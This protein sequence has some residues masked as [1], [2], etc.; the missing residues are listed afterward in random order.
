VPS[1][2]TVPS[3]AT[4]VDA[5][6]A[7]TRCIDGNEAVA[8]AAYALSETV[9][10]Y[11]ITPASPMGEFADEWAAKGRPNAWGVVPSV[12]QLQSEAGAAGAL[13][14]A[15]QAGSLGVTFTASQGLL[16]MIPEMFRIAGELTPTVIHVAA[17]TVATHA[18]SIFGDHSDVMAVR[19]TG[20]VMLSS[21]TPQEAH[22]LAAVSHAATLE[23]RLPFLHFMDGFRTSHELNVVRPIPEADLRR[24]IDEEALL[25][26]RGRGLDPDHPVLRGSA[27]NP[28]VFFQAR[29]AANTYVS[30]VPGIVQDVMDR[31]AAV[32]GRHY[33]LVEYHGAPDAEHVVV[34]MG[35]AVGPVR[36]VVDHLIS[37]AGTADGADGGAR[38]KVGLLY[39]RLFRPFPVEAFLAA[40]PTTVRRIAVL[41]RTK[42][43]GA[44]GEPLLEEVTTALAEAVMH[45][46]RDRLPLVVGARYGLASKEFTPAMVAGLF[47][48]L[49]SAA[50]KRRMTIGIID[51]VTGLSIPP[52]AGFALP[53]GPRDRSAVFFGL[54]ADGTVGANKN[55]TKIVGDLTDLHTQGYFVYDSK[56]S[57]ATT[58]SHL[59][60]SPDPIHS[61]YLIE[62]ADL[63]ACHQFGLLEKLDVT[64]SLKDGGILLLNAPFEADALFA[65]LPGA[66]RADIVA[67]GLEVH[68]IDAYRIAREVGLGGRINTVMQ[69]AYFALADLVDP[70]LAIGAIERAIRTSYGNRGE[71]VV[72]RNLAAVAQ[73]RS[74]L[75][76]IPV[77]TDAGAVEGRIDP[78]ERA[79]A[80]MPAG[81]EASDFVRR[82]TARMLEGEGELL[83]VS[84]LPVDGTFPTA[85]SRFEKRSLATELPIWDPDLCIDCGKCAIV[86]P[87]TAIQMK[88][89]EPD[90]LD[91]APDVFL[92]KEFKDRSLTGHLLTVQVAPDDCTGCGVCVETCPAVSRSDA[93]RK[94][95]RME[96][97]FE[98]R[99]V[100]RERYRFFDDIPYVDRSTVRTDTVKH[101]QLLQPLFE[102]SGAC[103]GCG[104][105]PYLKLLSQLYG[106]RSVVANATGCS[107]IYGGNLPTTPWSVDAAGR[108]PAWA[109]S[110]FEDNAEFGLGIRLGLDQQR[111]VAVHLLTTLGGEIGDE[112]VGSLLEADQDDEAEIAAQRERVVELRRRLAGIGGTHA[113]DARRLDQLA[114]ALVKRAV[115]IVG[116]DGW[117]YDIGYGGLD[118]V[119]ASGADVNVLVLDTE[120]Y[121]NTGGQ[122]SKSTNRAAVAKY[123]TSGKSSAKK[124]L[125]LIAMQYGTVYVAQIA[126]GANEMQTVKAFH[127]A[128][129]W[130]GPSLLL[131]Y[132]TCIA[133]GVDMRDS[134]KRQDLAVRTGYWPLFRYHP[135]E[136]A[137]TQP[138]RLDS[139]AP[140]LPL[141]DMLSTEGR[142]AMLERSDPERSALLRG[143][144][145]REVTERWS[146]YEQLAGVERRLTTQAEPDTDTA[147]DTVADADADV[148][149]AQEDGS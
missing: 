61:S 17:R 72:E 124:D 93:G 52:R 14:G 119:L 111:A 129:A 120:V 91:G 51:D 101:S 3:S 126:L 110:L 19:P 22:D 36:Q 86:C 90:A 10:I 132:S 125:G 137:G 128:A 38:G 80:L 140:S 70:D 33:G 71:E 37:E 4:D 145:Q 9:A 149:S 78:I 122:A 46:E 28:D 102:S 94:A 44:V 25:A 8:L 68:A 100:E 32:T 138:F 134:M 133:H 50:P 98:H 66:V 48:E 41:D 31:L 55:T 26:H 34:V 123:A 73:A 24:L 23:A 39:V 95:I 65:M 96:P 30:A 11:P 63:V 81:R 148:V 75:V 21:S 53:L 115:W 142:F 15:I 83:P 76:R 143:Q 88:A 7:T 103:A 77:P 12:S 104:E 139:K 107:S 106:D 16:L 131:A 64:G 20:W 87:H 135:A 57:G 58:V 121:S 89:Y 45:G 69:T 62:Q 67:R 97:A 74:S 18:L 130:P 13:H 59:R 49:A 147:A 105:T 47:D 116:G 1:T 56:K 113:V 35:S 42:E 5:A 109:N 84:A 85:T 146:Y 92:S 112:L 136:A 82:V 108:G 79:L 141:R 99:D 40:L 43:P 6:A 144:L 114:G 27:Q 54:G 29:E 2:V 118:H 117:A 60:F 127:E